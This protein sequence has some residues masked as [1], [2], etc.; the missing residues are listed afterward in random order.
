MKHFKEKKEH[1]Q[2]HQ[3]VTKD[4]QENS[5]KKDKHV[6]NVSADMEPCRHVHVSNTKNFVDLGYTVIS[7]TLASRYCSVF[8]YL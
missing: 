4:I 3:N 7:Q 5:K 6:A 2:Q 8:R 1:Q